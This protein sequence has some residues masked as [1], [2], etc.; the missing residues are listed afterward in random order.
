MSKVFS[1]YEI[2]SILQKHQGL[3]GRGQLAILST[4]LWYHGQN[5]GTILRTIELRLR[6]K[7]GRLPKAK[8][9]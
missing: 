4:K 6:R 2:P 3:I 9:L 1:Y 7:H 8:K 5:Y